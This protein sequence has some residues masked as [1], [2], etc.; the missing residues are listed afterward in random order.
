MDTTEAKYALHNERVTLEQVMHGVLVGSFNDNYDSA[1]ISKGTAHNH[2]AILEQR[3]H[4]GRVFCP[5]RLLPAGFAY[6]PGG[7]GSKKGDKGL[8]QALHAFHFNG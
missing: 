2:C 1:V 5:V 6:Q 4:E 7:T 8:F 3:I